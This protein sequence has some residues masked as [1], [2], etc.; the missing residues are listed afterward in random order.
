MSANYAI[1]TGKKTVFSVEAAVGLL[2]K[3]GGRMTDVFYVHEQGGYLTEE[4]YAAGMVS[5]QANG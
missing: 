5:E 3:K 4:Q 1:Q 2:G